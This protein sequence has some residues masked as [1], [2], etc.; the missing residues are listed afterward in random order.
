MREV[1]TEQARNRHESIR[2]SNWNGNSMDERAGKPESGWAS[3]QNASDW[4]LSAV[5]DPRPSP[6]PQTQLFETVGTL[7]TVAVPNRLRNC[8]SEP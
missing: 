1:A 6:Y 2:P 3:E 7:P 8:G 5:G 4:C